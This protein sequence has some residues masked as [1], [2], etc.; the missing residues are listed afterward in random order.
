MVTARKQSTHKPLEQ[1]TLP[2]E[3]IFPEG[4]VFDEKTNSLFTT[5]MQ[6]GTIF[7]TTLDQSAFEIL[8]PAGAN[9]CTSV[10]GVHMDF[11]NRRLFAAAGIT[12]MAFV[13]DA[14]TGQPLGKYSNGIA[15]EVRGTMGP[16]ATSPTLINDVAIIKGDAY[17]TDSYYPALFKLPKE[18]VQN[19][20]ETGKLEP[21]LPFEGTVLTYS[22]GA[23]LAS[24]LNLN[25]IV[26]TPDDRYLLVVQTNTG[27]LFR[28]D[29]L[30]KEV[31][32]VQGEGNQG[33]DGMLLWDDNLLIIDMTQPKPLT[34]LRL[35]SDYS[36]YTLVDHYELPGNVSPTN[37]QIIGDRLLVTESQIVDVLFGTQKERLPYRILTY[38][39]SVIGN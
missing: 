5:S 20:G 28:L 9:G 33:G 27:K 32:E 1:Y 31:I 22:K 26:S 39:L 8:S 36:A 15:P 14:D 29:V 19:R 10:L 34:R 18:S 2:G 7:R 11:D 17:F 12:G 37:A 35:K 16:N 3:G 4:L 30:N 23:G 38:P 6:Q 25:G 24:G 13:F 21:W